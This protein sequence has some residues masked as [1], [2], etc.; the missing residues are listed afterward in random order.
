MSLAPFLDV[1]ELFFPFM[2]A[3]LFS[4]CFIFTW[5][6]YSRKLVEITFQVNGRNN[7]VHYCSRWW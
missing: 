5:P 2:F 3:M 4:T 1:R 7:T 6:S